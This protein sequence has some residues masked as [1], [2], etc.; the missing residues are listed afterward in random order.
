MAVVTLTTVWMNLASD[1]TQSLVVEFVTQI[2]PS[3]QTPGEDRM[4]GNGRYRGLTAGATQ[5]QVQLAFAGVD[6]ATL[7]TLRAWDGQLVCYR[8]PSGEKFYGSYRSPQVSRHPYDADADVTLTVT[9][10]T[11]SEAV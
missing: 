11:F 10:K 7:A 9:E 3:P 5:N 4:Y 2:N 1:L 6:P 8:D